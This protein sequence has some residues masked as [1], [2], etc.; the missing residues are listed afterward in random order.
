M[1]LQETIEVYMKESIAIDHQ[2]HI[3]Q[4]ME[5]LHEAVAVPIGNFSGT[6]LIEVFQRR[7]SPK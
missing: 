4:V 6:Y 1:K 3:I 2:E 7:P 5:V